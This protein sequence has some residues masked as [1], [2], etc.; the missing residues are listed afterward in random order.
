MPNEARACPPRWPSTSITAFTRPR[1]STA[2]GT[3]SS[4]VPVRYKECRRL[5]S[6]PL[7]RSASASPPPT[8][9]PTEPN[10]RRTGTDA[11]AALTPARRTS[12][13]TTNTCTAS[14]MTLRV[15][16]TLEKNSSSSS[17][18][19]NRETVSLKTKSTRVNVTVDTRM[20]VA[21][22]RR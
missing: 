13:P 18:A 21:T 17:T 5:P 12:H 7:S 9:N 10:T 11:T 6:I 4:S 14:E 8:A 19:T 20:R 1:S 22:D 15:R 16:Y 2:M 3:N